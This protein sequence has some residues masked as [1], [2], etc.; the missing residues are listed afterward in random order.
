[1]NAASRRCAVYATKRALAL[2]P[3]PVRT[4]HQAPAAS[5][6]AMRRKSALAAR[7]DP[8]GGIPPHARQR[9]ERH[10]D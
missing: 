3:L 1:M 10:I 8:N 7:H 5:S 6:A 2:M 9:D 4:V